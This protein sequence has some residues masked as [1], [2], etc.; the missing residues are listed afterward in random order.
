MVQYN[1]IPFNDIITVILIKNILWIILHD[2]LHSRLLLLLLI[3]E[4]VYIS[5]LYL[6]MYYRHKLKA[7]E[8]RRGN[9]NMDNPDT[10]NIG[11]KIQNKDKWNKKHNTENY[12]DEQQRPPPKSS[13]W[14]QVFV[15]G[16]Q[17]MFLMLF[18]AGLTVIL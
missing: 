6:N 11:F 3:I 1:L 8:N 16:K 4:W 17:F 5:I 10:S 13:G 12:K 18:I 7:R 15:K 2:I 9:K 14:T